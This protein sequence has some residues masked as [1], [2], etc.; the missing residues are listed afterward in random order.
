MP[1]TKKLWAFICFTVLI[2]L[3]TLQFQYC[4]SQLLSHVLCFFAEFLKI[5]APWVGLWHN[6]SAPGVG[7]SHFLCAQGVRNSP[8]QKNSPGEWSSLELTDTF[9]NRIRSTVKKYGAEPRTRQAEQKPDRMGSP[10]GL[11]RLRID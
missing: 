3:N 10:G 4:F 5:I 11:V 1:P 6:F 8:F 7:V 2:F 9:N